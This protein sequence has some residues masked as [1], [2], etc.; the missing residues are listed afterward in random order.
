M[1]PACEPS[2]PRPA[3]PPIPTPPPL[4]LGH[5]DRHPA[6][7][8]CFVQR[9]EQLD[10]AE[11][12]LSLALVAVVGGT[13]PVVEVAQ[14]RWL[15]RQYF[16]IEEVDICI[17]QPEDFLIQF[18]SEADLE[19]VFRSPYPEAAP[20]KLIFKRWRR[21]IAATAEPLEFHILIEI[22]NMPAHAWS[23]ET[24]ASLLGSSCTDLKPTPDTMLRADLRRF[25][26]LA[27]TLDPN[28]I[29]TGNLLVIPEPRAPGGVGTAV[30]PA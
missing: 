23:L 9:S 1:P 16:Q 4:P 24:A 21:Q 6:P 19:R 14:V 12:D 10:Q 3:S 22:R 27:W 28:L 17:F 26:L 13:R 25:R 11:Q 18:R 2:P 5:P 20:F 8:Y 15:F 29:P 30:S 7:D